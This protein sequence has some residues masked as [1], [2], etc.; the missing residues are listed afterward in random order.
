M[1]ASFKLRDVHAFYPLAR[2]RRFAKKGKAGFDTRI[3]QKAADRQATTQ[4]SPPM[5]L[6]EFSDDGLQRHTVQWIAG[7]AGSHERMAYSMWQEI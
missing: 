5:P 7:M 2:P 3:I 4:L 6:D 1:A